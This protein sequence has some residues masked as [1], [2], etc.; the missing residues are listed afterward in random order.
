MSLDPRDDPREI[1]L[2]DEATDYPDAG[3]VL[4]LSVH[5]QESGVAPAVVGWRVVRVLPSGEHRQIGDEL[6]SCRAAA[7]VFAHTRFP[8]IVGWQKLSAT[9][10]AACVRREVSPSAKA[11]PS[12][13]SRRANGLRMPL[14]RV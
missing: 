14:W 1:L 3:S 7:R 6:F 5:A 12:L 11:A 10:T 8:N 2:E 13:P 9:V 4:I